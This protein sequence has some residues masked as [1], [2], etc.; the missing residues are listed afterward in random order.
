HD[1]DH[2]ENGRERRV[3]RGGKASRRSRR[4]QRTRGRLG[5][6]RDGRDRRANAATELNEW[7]LTADRVARRDR[8]PRAERLPERRPDRPPPRAPP[9]AGRRPTPRSRKEVLR[10]QARR[11]EAATAGV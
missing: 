3:V 4:D 8:E 7:S 6:L 11:P 2:E 5:D 9:L 1:L 10:P